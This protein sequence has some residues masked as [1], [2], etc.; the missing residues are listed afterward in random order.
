MRMLSEGRAT[1]P[2][3][4]RLFKVSTATIYRLFPRRRAGAAAPDGIAPPPR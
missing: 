1:V 4:A 3:V 2:E